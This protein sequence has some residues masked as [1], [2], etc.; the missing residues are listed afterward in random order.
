MLITDCDHDDVEPE[1]EVLG[2][3]GLELRLT[4]CRTAADVVA[5]G[6]DAEAL[7][8]QY[9]PIDADVLAALP[10]VRVGAR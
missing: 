7:I 9:A 8:V 2:A 1:R 4:Q 3:A 10:A 5:E 6:G